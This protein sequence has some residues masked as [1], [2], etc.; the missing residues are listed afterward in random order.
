MWDINP[1][2]IDN[3]KIRYYAQ[4]NAT[5][6]AY[7]FDAKI[8]GE[9][10]KGVESHFRLGLLQTKEDLLDDFYIEYYDDSGDVVNS[11]SSSVV[12]SNTIFPGY[13]PRQTEQLVTFSVFFQD[14]I[15]NYESFKLAIN[16]QFGTPLP[17]G[18]PTF[19]RYQDILR[20][21]AYFRTDLGIIY[22]IITK[23][24]SDK[25]KNKKV[26]NNLS[27]LSASLNATNLLDFNNVVSFNW[28]QDIYGRYYSIPNYL[29]GFRLNLKL[30]AEF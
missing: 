4:N 17:Y 15:P 11:A 12:D 20:S 19:N 14:K 29:S 8:N 22:D 7:G 23:D 27:R 5:A 28:L 25:F 18:P 30:V 24:N 2:E 26:L 16:M 3:V 9:F 13:I 21:K 10:I 1:Y 6:F